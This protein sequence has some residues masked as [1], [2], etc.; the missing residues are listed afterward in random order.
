MAFG[1]APQLMAQDAVIIY[2]ESDRYEVVLDQPVILDSQDANFTS[3]RDLGTNQTSDS[4]VGTPVE[5]PSVGVLP[6][7]GTTPSNG[8]SSQTQNSNDLGNLS[9][10]CLLYTSPSPRD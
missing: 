1:L 9:V 5:A 6:P 7:I 10:G 8:I 4:P 2:A 3:L